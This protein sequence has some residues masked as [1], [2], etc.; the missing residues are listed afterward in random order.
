MDFRNHHGISIGEKLAVRL[1][2][3]QLILCLL[4]SGGVTLLGNFFDGHD[5]LIINDVSELT[6]SR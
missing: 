5:V 2:G 3:V 1:H 6:K 4:F